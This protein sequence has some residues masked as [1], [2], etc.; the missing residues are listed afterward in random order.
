MRGGNLATGS[1]TQM[2][3]NDQVKGLKESK[4]VRFMSDEDCEKLREKYVKAG[5]IKPCPQTIAKLL[6]QKK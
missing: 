1:P 4:K 6:V 3:F 2:K 5:I